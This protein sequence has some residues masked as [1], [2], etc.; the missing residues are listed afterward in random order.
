MSFHAT[1][2]AELAVGVVALYTLVTAA[3][4]AIDSLLSLARYYEVP[5]ELLGMTVIAVGTSLPEI[6]S[7]VVA[8]LGILSGSLDY[9]IASAVVIGGN[10]G[11]S[12]TQQTLLLGL[13]LVGYGRLHVSESLIRGTYLPM[14]VG[15]AL[16]LIV[17][18][19]GTISRLDGLILLIG[20]AVYT[21]YGYVHRP[22]SFSVPEA[23][24][25]NVRRDG[26]VAIGALILVVISASLLLTVA[27]LV[28]DSLALGGS[29]VGVI[30]LG[31]ASALP[32]L[33]TVLDAVRR[34]APNIALGTLLGSNVVNPLLGIG[35]GGTL[36]TY[37][38]PSA[39]VL[40]DLPFKLVVAV[41]LLGYLQ[42]V[43]DR[44]LTRRDGAYLVVLYFVFVTTRLLFFPAQ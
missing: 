22:R 35:L 3:G 9:R 39:V 43:S 20:F 6:T 44:S 33:S 5:D 27:E 11:S 38:V 4:R 23:A 1:L 8:S 41:G 36:S 12:T 13:F 32:E 31:V 2:A 29:M 28:V 30:T 14:V 21:Y 26:L 18:L 37:Q 17:A 10:M 40:W 24:S 19:D 42:F 7:H 25:T 34:R 15:F 16:T